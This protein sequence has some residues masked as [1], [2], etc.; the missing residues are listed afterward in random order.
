MTLRPI[1]V[2]LLVTQ[3]AATDIQLTILQRMTDVRVSSEKCP[4]GRWLADKCVLDENWKVRSFP[5][6]PSCLVHAPP[7]VP[8]V[9]PESPHANSRPLAGLE[10]Y[11]L[12]DD[13]ISPFPPRVFA[14]TSSTRTHA[15]IHAG[16]R[17]EWSPGRKRVQR[18]A[19]SLGNHPLSLQGIRMILS[20]RV[21]H[22]P[23]T[24]PAGAC[25]A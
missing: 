24:A 5:I 14:Q 4:D 7:V 15:R 20:I 3:A 22:S 17:R 16:H 12:T 11:Q 8:R 2:L 10:S 13:A 9:P 1:A 19:L 6:P 18:K 25:P 23:L 21:R